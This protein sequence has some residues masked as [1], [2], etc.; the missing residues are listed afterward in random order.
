[1]KSAQRFWCHE[2]GPVTQVAKYNKMVGFSCK[3]ETNIFL[4][5]SKTSTTKTHEGS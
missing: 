1:M 5:I 2:D 3:I 4:N